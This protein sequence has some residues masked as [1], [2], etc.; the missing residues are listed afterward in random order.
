MDE[1]E[2]KK[3][4]VKTEEV[5]VVKAE[6]VKAEVVKAE[7]VKVEEKKD[8]QETASEL[9]GFDKDLFATQLELD[10]GTRLFEAQYKDV[11][12]KLSVRKPTNEEIE[13][14][15]WEYSKYFNR[16][17]TEGISP[18]SA[19]LAILKENGS[20]IDEDEDEIVKLAESVA[21]L[22][23]DIETIDAETRDYKKLLSVRQELK[24]TRER[25]QEKRI[26]KQSYLFHT[27][28]QKCEEY[29]TRVVVAL[30]TEYA[31]GPKKGLSFFKD[32]YKNVLHKSKPRGSRII[33]EFEAM[34]AFDDQNFV[35][36]CYINYLTLINGLASNF[37]ER[38]MPEDK[39]FDWEKGLSEKEKGSK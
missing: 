25:L 31:E 8:F 19:V 2:V 38:E 37:L 12:L 5:K 1:K 23:S 24:E 33:E 26:K 29:K 21:S 18:Q 14:G 11:L 15:D 20:W 35:V 7:V 30:V 36:S 16:A 22:E 27:A 3:E 10:T 32:H 39:I 34:Q 9:T 17:I 4:E 13:K 6:V 28:E